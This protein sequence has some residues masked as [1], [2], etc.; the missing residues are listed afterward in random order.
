M[1]KVYDYYEQEV[2]I[3]DTVS[4]PAGRDFMDGTVEKIRVN[5]RNNKMSQV[6]V[7]NDSGYK[8]WKYVKNVI[9]RPSI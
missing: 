9:K 3:G 6:Y 8:K 4:F 7:L 5:I 1:S 2:L